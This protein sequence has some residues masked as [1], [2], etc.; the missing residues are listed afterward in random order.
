M[1]VAEAGDTVGDGDRAEGVG[2]RVV[3]VGVAVGERVRVVG[4]GLRLPGDRV[5]V[6]ES[7]IEGGCVPVW[8]TLGPLELGV[9]VCDVR[10]SDAEG[11]QVRVGR[12]VED[13]EA[14]EEGDVVA[15]E[16]VRVW[17][18]SD[19][20]ALRDTEPVEAVGLRVWDG[21]SVDRV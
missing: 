7:V 12:S 15:V 4:L 14:E 13:T 17:G 11:V 19:P 18:V 3:A 16:R 2:V 10:L 5:G 20:E 1:A 21:V 9:G 6:G 8:L